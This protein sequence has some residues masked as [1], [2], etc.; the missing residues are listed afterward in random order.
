MSN[1]LLY[2]GSVVAVAVLVLGG[3]IVLALTLYKL[4]VLVVAVETEVGATQGATL[5][6]PPTNASEPFWWLL[7]GA[8]GMVAALLAPVHIALTGIMASSVWL[9]DS[10]DY[11]RVLELVSHPISRIYLLVL[12]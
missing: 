7:F 12:I 2:I 8:G 3:G 9:G 5:S 11:S 6:S 1:E 4:S 10:F